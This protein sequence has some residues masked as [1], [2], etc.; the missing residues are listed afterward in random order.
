MKKIFGKLLGTFLL[1]VL[2]AQT[3]LSVA[4]FAS[5]ANG[6]SYENDP[7]LDPRAMED[8][9]YNPEAVY[10]FS[11]DPESD[12]LGSYARYDFSDPALVASSTKERIDY[13]AD[14]Q[15]MYKLWDDM[16]AQ[17]KSIEEIARAVSALRNEL[18]LEAYK[19]NPEG[20]ASAKASNLKKYGNEMGPTVESLFEKYG[21]WEKVLIKSFST[22]AG[23]DACL[24]LY[25]IEFEHNE[26]INGKVPD[27]AV[28]TVKKGDYLSKIAR[29]YY[30]TSSDWTKIY[31]A[32][33]SKIADP[34]VIQPEIQ[35]EIPLD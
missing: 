6:F 19:D 28:Y 20:L 27:E 16:K 14:F 9:N 22:N 1:G 13:L 34:N 21:S 10:G 29:K 3:F 12:R 15:K 17:G 4:A 2:C 31:N 24:G 5:E 35:L 30:G 11:P 8:V 26:R 25:D 23:M 7:R 33:K 18:R 32:N